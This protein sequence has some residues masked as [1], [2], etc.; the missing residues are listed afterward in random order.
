MNMARKFNN[1]EITGTVI[2]NPNGQHMKANWF[3]VNCHAIGTRESHYPDCSSRESYA[4]P[5]TCE[6]PKK[7]APRKKW[8]I[9]KKQFVYSKPVGWWWHLDSSWWYKNNKK[10]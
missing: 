3:C 9:F 10:L 5:A 2:I 4:I 7:N 8:E 1:R 6:V